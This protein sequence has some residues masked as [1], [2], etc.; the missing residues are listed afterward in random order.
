LIQKKSQSKELQYE[1]AGQVAR[2]GEQ[3]VR[4]SGN[5]LHIMHGSREGEQAAVTL[6][7]FAR[8]ITD[9]AAAVAKS[10]KD[11]TFQQVNFRQ[12]IADYQKKAQQVMEPIR[13]KLRDFMIPEAQHLVKNIDNLMAQIKNFE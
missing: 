9:L 10:K 8:Q 6:V 7:G 5:L 3:I 13:R 12:E 2:A 1:I 11:P 4:Y